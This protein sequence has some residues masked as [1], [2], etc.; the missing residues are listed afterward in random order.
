MS[1]SADV[2]AQAKAEVDLSTIP[3]GKNVSVYAVARFESCLMFIPRLS[4]NGEANP[5]S[6]DIVPSQRSK[7]PRIQNGNLCEI[8][9]QTN[10]AYRDRNGLSCLVLLSC[11][12]WQSASG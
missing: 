2:L 4:S 7:R 1:A 10:S 11:V 8:L 6:F 3:V 9:S 5:F 12:G